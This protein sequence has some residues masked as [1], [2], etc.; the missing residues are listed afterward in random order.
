MCSKNEAQGRVTVEA[1]FNGCPVIGYASAGTLEIIK[2]K[3]N[4]FLYT[5]IYDILQKVSYIEQHYDI[6]YL[7]HNAQQ[8]AQDNFS[9]EL[10]GERLYKLYIDVL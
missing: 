8:Y 7:I 1:M 6:S 9:E 10:Y 5:D 3:E 2:D 4:G